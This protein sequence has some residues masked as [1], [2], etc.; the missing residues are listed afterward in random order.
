M[1]YLS[2]T[3]REDRNERPPERVRVSTP[4]GEIIIKVTKRKGQTRVHI[5]ADRDDYLV[6]REVLQLGKW[7]LQRDRDGSKED[8]DTSQDIS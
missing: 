5:D 2:L 7:I 4:G 1:G 3:I 6:D 8:N